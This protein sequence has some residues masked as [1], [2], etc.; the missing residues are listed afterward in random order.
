MSF[1]RE[2]YIRVF[3]EEPARVG[4][5]VGFPDLK[6]LHNEWM[7][8]MLYGSE[9]MTL[10]AHRLSYKTTCVS[11]VLA[12]YIALLPK[13]S[14]LFI[15]KTDTDVKEIILQTQKILIHPQFSYAASVI[16]G[17]PLE[18]L[19][20]SAYEINTNYN[21][22]TRGTSQLLG[23][24]TGGSVTG[25]HFDRIFTDDIVNLKD[26]TSTAERD[27]T[28]SIYQELQN[29]RTHGG[30]IINTATPWHKDDAVSALMPNVQRYDCYSTG[31]MT[32][33]LI[34]EK[35]RSMSPSLFAANYELR[36]IAA[37]NAL[38]STYPAETDDESML[39]DGYAH[40]D[41]AY[42]GEDYTAFTCARR[43]GDTLY[44]Y[45]RMWRAHV[46]TVMDA[47]LADSDRLMCAPIYCETNADKGYLARELRSRGASVRPYQE[48]MNKYHKISTFLRKW[49]GGVVFLAGTDPAYIAQIMDYNEQA[50]HDDAPDSAAC[51]C[52]ILDR[53]GDT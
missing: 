17:K 10:L 24:G 40:I 22:S 23:I 45:G 8:E 1:T 34:E 52:R 11:V 53:R 51:I 2:D 48:R 42:G 32:P 26:R 31:I 13:L 29:V 33:E 15:R 4:H 6:P 46:D 44:L 39:Y 37:E 38:F 30:R 14:T 28:K 5:M 3:R 12:I 18:L 50:E 7:K 43:D 27:R 35:R 21:T 49:W 19:T 41:A 9:D 20:A 47:T 36:H 16:M 25:K